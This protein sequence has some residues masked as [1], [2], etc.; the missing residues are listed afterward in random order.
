MSSMDLLPELSERLNRVV[1]DEK[2]VADWQDILRRVQPGPSPTPQRRPR[3]VR[4]VLVAVALLLLLAGIAT[5]TYFALR[6]AGGDKAGLTIFTGDPTP[7][8]S[9]RLCRTFGCGPEAAI[10]VIQPGGQ[11]EIIWRC[12]HP[13]YFCGEMTSMAW[14]ADGRELAFTMDQVGGRSGYVGLHI[15]D[16]RTGRDR[17]VPR[18]VKGDTARQLPETSFRR[19]RERAVRELGCLFPTNV[20]WSAD[21]MSLAYDCTVNPALPETAIFVIAADGSRRR[22]LPTRLPVAVKPSWSP[23]G[24]QLVFATGPRPSESDVYVVK[25]DGSGRTLIARGG[26]APAWSPNGK[27]IAYRAK[28][29][30]RLASPNGD[31]VTPEALTRE[32]GRASPGFPAWSPDGKKLAFAGPNGIFVVNA[33]GRGLRR[34]T[35]ENGRGVF[36]FIRPAWTPTPHVLPRPAIPSARSRC[37]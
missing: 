26:T 9:G 11:L 35:R 30:L 37:C 31:D 1:P 19:Y 24:T 23:D 14:S 36:D 15:V 12:P 32:C 13:G 29:G 28:C 6:G 21:G 2:V 10:A 3:R 20:A 33:D 27:T 7:P 17:Q 22:R 25:L 34:V 16:T 4:L 5:G 18:L 8:P